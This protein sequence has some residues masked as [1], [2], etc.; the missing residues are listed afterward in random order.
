M[1][2]MK[3]SCPA[4]GEHFKVE[5]DFI[6]QT[7]ACSECGA[8][9]IVDTPP[10]LVTRQPSQTDDLEMSAPPPP[11]PKPVHREKKPV[12]LA[13]DD[14]ALLQTARIIYA[15]FGLFGGMLGLHDL[16]CGRDGCATLKIVLTAIGCVMFQMGGFAVL[17]VVALWCV[18]DII[19]PLEDVP[20]RK[21][22]VPW[23]Y[24]GVLITA[25]L[26]AVA[27]NVY[28]TK[29]RSDR[30]MRDLEIPRR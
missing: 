15:I 30:V 4:C 19:N 6:G 16:F 8:Q 26:G 9:F 14:G 27:L 29:V 7:V 17:L 21:H 22:R 3:I 10:R 20:K 5:T 18:V 2:T 1:S 11:P 28:A 24:V 23:L 25:I 13:D 12:A